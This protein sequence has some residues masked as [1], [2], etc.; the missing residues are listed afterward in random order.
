MDDRRRLVFQRSSRPRH[1]H[2]RGWLRKGARRRATARSRW[3][4]L[5]S[6]SRWPE[7]DQRRSCRHAHNEK[8]FTLNAIH[9]TIEDDDRALWL[10]SACGL[11]RI[12]RSELDAWLA[13][14]KH[15][16]DTTIWNAADG[17]RLRS[18]APTS[19]AP[20]V[21]KSIDGKLWIVAGSVQVVDP[22]H[23]A[24][25]KLAPPV[26]VEQIV[27]DKKTYWQSLRRSPFD[28]DAAGANRDLQ[29]DYTALSLV[30]AEKVHFKYQLEGQDSDWREVVNDRRADPNL[31]PR[32]YRFRVIASNNS[33]VSERARRYAGILHRPGILPDELVSRRLRGSV[34]DA[35]VGSLSVS[36]PAVA[37]SVRNDS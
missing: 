13:N 23:L 31:P 3:N 16:I 32:T 11:V 36:C 26:H 12:T 24:I 15:R 25:N 17:L 34:F 14:P 33:G 37:P 10:N 1:L 9:S 8:W 6:N 5:G 30:A 19:F 18:I 35:A 27:A 28:L 2:R 29:I 4:G 20:R 22:H 7:P 21:T